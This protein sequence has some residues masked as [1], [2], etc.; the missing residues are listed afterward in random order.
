[1]PPAALVRQDGRSGVFLAIDGKAQF[2]PIRAGL[3]AASGVE[4]LEGLG[5]GEAVIVTRARPL[6]DGDRV[7]VTD[8]GGAQ[9]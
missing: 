9:S 5:G 6:V 4:V 8:A 1:V 2:V 7:R 3:R